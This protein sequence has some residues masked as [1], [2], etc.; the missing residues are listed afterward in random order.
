ML[1][2][3]ELSR[4]E[5]WAYIEKAY[6]EGKKLREDRQKQSEKAQK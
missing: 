3:K 2:D 6:E 5:G 1:D 4:E